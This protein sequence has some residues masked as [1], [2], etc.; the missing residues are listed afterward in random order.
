MAKKY[1]IPFKGLSGKSGRIDI[2]D[3]S[4]SGSTVTT[5]T[6]APQPIVFEEE[7]SE[8]L[9]TVVR[10][11]TGYLNLVETAAGELDGVWPTTNT[12]RPV[13]AYYDNTLI[14]SGF[15]QAQSFQNSWTPARRTVSVP[16]ISPLGLIYDIDMPTYNPPTMKALNVL[17]ADV[18]DDLKAKGADYTQ[19][20]WPKMSVLLS[21]T[22]SSLTACPFNSEHRPDVASPALFKPNT[23][24]WFIESLCNAFGWMVHETPDT[25]VFSKFDHTGNYILCSATNLRTLSGASELAYTGATQQDITSYATPADGDGQVTTI[26]PKEEIELSYDGQYIKS[27]Q[28]DFSHLT[29]QSWVKNGN[30]YVAWL[31]SNTPE[32]SGAKLLYTN[33]FGNNGKLANEGATACSCGSSLEQLECIL[34]NLP[35][36]TVITTEIFKVKFFVRPTSSNFILSY[37][38]AWG[39]TMLDIIGEDAQDL[40]IHHKRLGVKVKVGNKYYVGG[41]EWSTTEQAAFSTDDTTISWSITNTPAGMPI[42][43]TFTEVTPQVQEDVKQM[44]AVSD[45]TLKEIE[46]VY[47]DYL[48]TKNETDS[49][50]V[51]GGYGQG[52]AT[53]GMGLTCY[54]ENN[55]Q[56]GSSLITASNRFTNY[57]YLLYSQE[58]LRIRFKRIYNLT[59]WWYIVYATFYSHQWRV[60]GISQNPYDDEYEIILQRSLNA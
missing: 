40:S 18:V 31:R 23:M 32:L 59:Y 7:D 56:I 60:I 4:Y 13:K 37:D 29:Y 33:T 16:I 55:S 28:F 14:F 35:N 27:T 8:D 49:I 34:V 57:T 9:L 46:T 1:T 26:M 48:V 50:K 17:L 21:A 22:V 38:V 44:V 41:G 43:V 12:S 58:R 19:V 30:Q 11:K 3:T 53:V 52:T 42:E 51:A 24:G 54:R 10:Y 2:Y 47:S 6:G 25:I 39:D 20:V 36:S 15:I 45:I 5:L